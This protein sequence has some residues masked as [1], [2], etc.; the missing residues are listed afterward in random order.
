MRFL[1]PLL[2][3]VAGAACL[4]RDVYALI[5]SW[6]AD[7]AVARLRAQPGGIVTCERYE[8]W[9]DGVRRWSPESWYARDGYEL[10]HLLDILPGLARDMRVI[11]DD[12]RNGTRG[13]P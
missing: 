3:A 6:L 11:P 13:A 4:S 2:I 5:Y 1:L 10:R 8:T 9:S 7:R 12:P